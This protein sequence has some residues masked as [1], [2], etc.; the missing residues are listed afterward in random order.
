M[1]QACRDTSSMSKVWK[2]RLGLAL[3][4]FVEFGWVVVV[5]LASELVIWG[6]SRALAPV[7]LEFFSSI[8]GMVLIFTLMTVAYLFSDSVDYVYRCH[9]K[10]KVSVLSL[11]L[12]YQ[13]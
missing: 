7:H 6:L 2:T 13:Y 5:Y 4:N 8:F 11:D 3:G 10:S 12:T 9:I 1:F